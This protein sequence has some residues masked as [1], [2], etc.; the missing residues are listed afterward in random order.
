MVFGIA[1]A[2]HEHEKFNGL[3]IKVN[4]E[5]AYNGPTRAVQSLLGTREEL[6][7]SQIKHGNLLSITVFTRLY[8]KFLPSP[9]ND[10]IYLVSLQ[11]SASSTCNTQKMF[12]MGC[13][14]HPAI[15]FIETQSKEVLSKGIC[16]FIRD[17]GKG[18]QI[19]TTTRELMK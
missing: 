14:T 12:R 11:M 5:R 3:I 2:L 1:N 6:G 17:R 7:C 19:D 13:K 10:Q 15:Q 9:M 18:R 4:P 8:G 16:P